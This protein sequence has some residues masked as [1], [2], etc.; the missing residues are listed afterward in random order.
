MPVAVHITPQKMSRQ[1]YE[2][3]ISDLESSGSP[4]NGRLYH[5]AYGDESVRMFEVWESEE[6][7]NAH[8]DRMFSQLQ[9]AG[10]DAGSVEVHPVHAESARV[11]A[12]G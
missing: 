11:P 10:V 8:R 12:H 7:F 5:A 9:A 4:P 6:Q 2:T 3:M 1:E